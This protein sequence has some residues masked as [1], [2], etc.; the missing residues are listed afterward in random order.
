MIQFIPCLL[1]LRLA[2]RL[3]NPL[4]ADFTIVAIGQMLDVPSHPLPLLLTMLDP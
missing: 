3:A 4:E 2:R 1:R